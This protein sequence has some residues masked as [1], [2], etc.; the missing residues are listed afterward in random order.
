MS[1]ECPECGMVCFC[2]GDIESCL[3]N[4]VGY[5]MNCTHCQDE[6]TEDED[7]N[8][9]ARERRAT[10]RDEELSSCVCGAWQYK[11]GSGYIQYADCVC[12]NT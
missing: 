2:K 3:M 8:D 9:D 4:D 6:D 1:H 7:V 5:Q 10:L 12:G 11:I